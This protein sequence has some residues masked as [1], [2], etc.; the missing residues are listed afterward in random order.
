MSVW[1]RLGST[2]LM[3]AED[4]ERFL[5]RCAAQSAGI[6]VAGIPHSFSV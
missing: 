6:S 2:A 5:I 3:T 1:F 4:S